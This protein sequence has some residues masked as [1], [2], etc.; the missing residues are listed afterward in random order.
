MRL[1]AV[2]RVKP[3]THA[4]KRCHSGLPGFLFLS[5]AREESNWLLLQS[6][7]C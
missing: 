7:L 6:N 5:F 2:V 1:G 4:A 3:P